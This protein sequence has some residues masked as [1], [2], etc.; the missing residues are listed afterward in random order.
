MQV[1]WGAFAGRE[2]RGG[3]MGWLATTGGQEAQA[4]GSVRQAGAWSVLG[5]EALTEHWTR[6][7]QVEATRRGEGR[8]DGF[9]RQEAG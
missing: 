8:K 7:Q 3:G 4:T 9:L 2:G 6:T 1:D 5:A